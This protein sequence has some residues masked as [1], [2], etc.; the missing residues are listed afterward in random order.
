MTAPIQT[1]EGTREIISNRII[2]ASR[3]LVFRAFCEPEHLAQW[4]GPNGFHNTFHEFDLRSGGHWRFI[5]HGPDG[6]DYQNHSVFLD[7][8]KR[9]RIVFR[10]LDP[11]HDFQMT[12][13]F[14]DEA[15]NTRLTWRMLFE[16]AEHCEQVKAFV[17]EANE[18]NFDRLEAELAKMV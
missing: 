18:Q 14:A 1:A 3:E 2:A 15:G 11:V 7:V 13:T 17:V 9:E 12:I 5:M 4:W 8:V 6:V 16:S 10:H